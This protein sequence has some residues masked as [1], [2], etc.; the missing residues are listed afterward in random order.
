MLDL[1]GFEAYLRSKERSRN[2]ISCYIR[3]SKAFIIG[4]AAGQIAVLIS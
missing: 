3:D 1:S 2:T 4:T